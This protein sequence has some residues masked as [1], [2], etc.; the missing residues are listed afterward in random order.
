MTRRQWLANACAA[1]WFGGRAEAPLVIPVHLIQDGKVKWRPAVL[2]DFWWKMW[3]DAAR[4]FGWCGIRFQT[5]FSIGEVWKPAFREPVITPLER[6]AIN[7]TITDRIPMD[8]DNGRN[9]GGVTTLHR[10]Y[11]LCMIALATA[12]GNQIPFFSV[13]TC[14]HEL[15]HALTGDIFENRSPGFFGQARESRIDW[16]AT[17]MWLFHGE[18]SIR[19]MAAQYLERLRAGA[20]VNGGATFR[21]PD[22]LNSQGR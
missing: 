15:L 9:L 20:R 12:H 3:P 7:L 4:E 8:W 19:R 14:V 13:N 16:F 6:G 2:R 21:A 17:V 1:A 22:A 10:G 18:A 11:H 5:T